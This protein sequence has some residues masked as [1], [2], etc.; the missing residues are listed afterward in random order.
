MYLT[1]WASTDYFLGG[2]RV[3]FHIENCAVLI[4]KK[5]K[6]AGTIYKGSKCCPLWTPM[7]TFVLIKCFV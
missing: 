5:S 2:S 6:G 7:L 4:I 3:P 1:V